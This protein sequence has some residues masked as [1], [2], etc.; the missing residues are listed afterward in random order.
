[1][2]RFQILESKGS[3]GSGGYGEVFPCHE[4][5]DGGQITARDL[6]V[7]LCTLNGDEDDAERIQRFKNGGRL[8]RRL[9]HPNVLPVRAVGKTTD[10]V[11]FIVMPC[12]DGGNL[13]EWLTETPRTDEQCFEVFGAVLEAVAYAHS[14]NILHRD[15]KPENVLFLAGAP[16]VADFDLAK[17]LTPETAVTGITRTNV[18]IGT[19]GYVAPEQWTDLKR[20][21]KPADVYALGRLLW[22]MLSGR[23]PAHLAP[24]NL[25]LVAAPYR[26]FIEKAS[27]YRQHDRYGSATEM[28]RAFEALV[29]APPGSPK[30]LAQEL[31]EKWNGDEPE[32]HWKTLKNMD[33]HFGRHLDNEELHY[34]LVPF[35]PPALL[36]AWM[37]EHPGGFA[38][39]VSAVDESLSG[40]LPFDD[41]DGFARFYLR[42]F[43][44]SA[45][46]ELRV[47]A[48]KKVLWLGGG[49]N[50]YPVANMLRAVLRKVVEQDDVAVIVEAVAGE[51]NY[52][53]WF[54]IHGKVH[55][56]VLEA[57]ERSK[58]DLDD[59]FPW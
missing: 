8:G 37:R 5:G 39:M 17:D 15:I 38:Q 20:V 35:L 46:R 52:A 40:Y 30:L 24:L 23:P 29:A 48:I 22:R 44:S 27:E 50:R 57:F 19:E 9:K 3:L 21:G 59:D 12:A 56:E 28:L 16:C 54:N 55:A 4:I 45:D 47:R 26:A 33:D 14:Q 49:H 53:S 18:G 58:E 1:M 32:K 11:P 34:E 43:E 25:Q 6:A 51:R 2:A 31:A 42:I 10:G 7:K 41:C 36:D 13:D